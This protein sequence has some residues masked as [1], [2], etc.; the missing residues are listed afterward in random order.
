MSGSES[1]HHR[2][3]DMG[4]VA[5]IPA[6][7][8]DRFQWL[9]EATGSAHLADR[10]LIISSYP[11][12]VESA[13]WN[14][15]E[16][17]H[18]PKS[19]STGSKYREM[20]RRTRPGE[21]VAVLD[22]DDLWLPEKV[23][24]LGAV[25]SDKKTG[26]FAH[27]AATTRQHPSGEWMPTGIV[28]S[29]TPNGTATAFR[30]EMLTHPFVKPFFDRLDWA[31]DPFLRYAAMVSGVGIH[32]TDMVLAHVRY[33]DNNMSHPPVEYREF[34]EWRKRSAARFLAGWT[35]I[36]E[37]TAGLPGRP[38]EVDEKVAEFRRLLHTNPLAN[39]VAWALSR[40]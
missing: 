22:D 33:H 9:H 18:E 6:H 16:W 2:G 8:P 37:M 17:V 35:L 3:C 34:A 39:R 27:A 5:F 4:V 24:V 20:L 23:P 30:R 7:F 38:S 40:G 10:T 11:R 32:T 36:D 21:I 29:T 12:P 14:G 15:V 28:P 26:Y 1:R 25:F 31:V 19:A 13:N